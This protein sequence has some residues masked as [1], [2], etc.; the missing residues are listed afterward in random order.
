[1]SRPT[2][3]CKCGKVRLIDG[4]AYAE[5]LMGFAPEGRRRERHGRSACFY[6]PTE[7]AYPMVRIDQKEGQ[8]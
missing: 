7:H 5:G 1:M 8:S 4:C 3:A 2:K 6:F